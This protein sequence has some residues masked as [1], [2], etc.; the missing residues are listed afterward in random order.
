MKTV[1]TFKDFW[2]DDVAADMFITGPA[3]S[4]K[5]TDLTYIVEYAIEKLDL[6][7]VVCAHTHKACSI[8]MEKLPK[9]TH[10]TTLHSFLKKRPA[11]N[12]EAKNIKHALSNIVVGQAEKIDLL[13]VD[14]RSMVGER[15]ADD[16]R[17]LQGE[18]ENGRELLKVLWLG[19]DNQLP[20]VGDREGAIPYGDYQVKLTKNYRNKDKLMVPLRQLV[21]FIESGGKAVEPL[22]ENEC[23]I[24]GKDIVAEYNSDSCAD[25]IILAYTNRRVQELN[26]EI[27]GRSTPKELD[28]V[29]IATTRQEA[30]FERA[31]AKQNI[32]VLDLPFGDPLT[33]GSKYKTLEHLLKMPGISYGHFTDEQ[34]GSYVHAYV[35]GY[36]DYKSRH[37]E[38]LQTAVKANLGTC[39]TTKAKA[40]RDFLT[41]KDCV[42]CIDFPHAM[43]VHKSQGSTYAN[44]YLDTQDLGICASRNYLLYLK[45]F[46]VG[47]SRSSNIVITN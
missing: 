12:V 33:F 20:P 13:I 11:V 46:Y 9:G 34:G 37:E 39:K 43:T 26:A 32:E 29:F 8:L 25:K 5:T 4:G 2:A 16:V 22:Q 19:D 38:L 35:F 7:V 42:M 30:T 3:G 45:L 14:E 24:R 36:Q 1:Q 31:V 28:Q 18:D 10:I 41:F 17:A 15:D 44:V 21:T 6:C 27:Q 23:F 47:M 40:W